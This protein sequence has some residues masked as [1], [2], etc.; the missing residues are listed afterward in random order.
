MPETTPLAFCANQR[1]EPAQLPVRLA[2]GR[3]LLDAKE[4]REAAGEFR[5]LLN[6]PYGQIAQT[7]Y[8][9]ARALEALK[10]PE[11][12]QEALKRI[13]SLVGGDVRNRLLLADLNANDNNDQETLNLVQGAVQYDPNNLAVLVRLAD[14]QLRLSIA[15]GIAKDAIATSQ[16]IL[17]LS[18]SNVRGR[19]TLARSLGVEKKYRA[20]VEAYDVILAQD[21]DYLVPQ[22]ERARMLY[23]ANDF[24]AGAAAYQQILT[25]PAD[26]ILHAQLANLAQRDPRADA[27]LKKYAEDEKL[28]GKML[29]SPEEMIKMAG[30]DPGLQSGLRWSFLTTK[31]GPRSRNL[32]A[33]K[34]KSKN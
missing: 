6:R 33:S 28:T 17:Q 14:V 27:P 31:P 25:P 16:K 29:Q 26:V 4:Y 8:G 15:P 7:Y 13:T 34:P 2:L 21:R 12:A 23:S 11:K 32:C 9:L 3:I 18:P 20:A 22:R 10:E 24:A 19:L 5:E 1:N 30:E